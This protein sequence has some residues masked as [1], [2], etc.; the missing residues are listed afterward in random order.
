MIVG[1]SINKCVEVSQI[2]I[3][4]NKKIKEIRIYECKPPEPTEEGTRPLRD[5]GWMWAPG[6]ATPMDKFPEGSRSRYSPGGIIWVKVIAED[7]T[8]GLGRT[9]SGH[10]TR[11]LIRE[12]LAPLVIGQEVGAIELRVNLLHVDRAARD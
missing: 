5:Q 12:C 3:L 6:Q 8:F 4:Y 11:T 1:H 7:G 10:V 2:N 9:D